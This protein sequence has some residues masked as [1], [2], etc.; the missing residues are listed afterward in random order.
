MQ[1]DP[2]CSRSLIPIVS[3]N[4]KDQLHYANERKKLASA[5]DRRTIIVA[6]VKF[7]IRLT[8]MF[9]GLVVGVSLR[10]FYRKIE[11]TFTEEQGVGSG[12]VLKQ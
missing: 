7:T 6:R 1:Y 5:L 12:V 8:R 2:M 9:R 4:S 3:S 10:V 11:R